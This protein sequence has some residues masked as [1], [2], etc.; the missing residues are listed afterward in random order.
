MLPVVETQGLSKSYGKFPALHGVDISVP[1]GSVFALLGA[2]GAGK[3]TIIKILLN[4]ISPTSGT[5]K[6]LGVE[7]RSIG[8]GELSQ[9]GYVSENQ[10]MPG[11]LRV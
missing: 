11:R 9:I 5:S 7:S 6:M 3:T 2:S 8:V 10:L 4:M 1:Q